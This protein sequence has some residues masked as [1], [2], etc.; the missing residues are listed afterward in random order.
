MPRYAGDRQS[1]G[2]YGY[3][4][5]PTKPLVYVA[6]QHGVSRNSPKSGCCTFATYGG[7]MALI[8]VIYL[9]L[10]KRYPMI[11]PSL[12]GSALRRRPKLNAKQK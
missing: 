7:K 6:A 10:Y 3:R 8:S 4:T 9:L 12:P 5:Y 1:E 2:E 11:S